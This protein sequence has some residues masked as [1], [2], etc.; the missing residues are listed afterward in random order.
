MRQGA[1]KSAVNKNLSVLFLPGAVAL[2]HVVAVGILNIG[3]A[4]AEIKF[5][6]RFAA[7][8]LLVKTDLVLVPPVARYLVL[9]VV[10]VYRT[11]KLCVGIVALAERAGV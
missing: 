2:A 9:F 10:K 1:Q 5:V 3:L 7:G 11:G 4:G 6:E 8:V